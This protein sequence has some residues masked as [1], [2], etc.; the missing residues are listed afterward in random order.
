[1]EDVEAEETGFREISHMFTNLFPRLDLPDHK[2]ENVPRM[3]E[4]STGCVNRRNARSGV[5]ILA[6][7]QT[8][9]HVR[10]LNY[11]KH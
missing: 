11:V 4:S 10:I 5:R 8:G 3:S 9:G 2:N 7:A 6:I 1:M